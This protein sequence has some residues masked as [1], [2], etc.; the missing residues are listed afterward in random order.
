MSEPLHG[1]PWRNLKYLAG[2]QELEM[3][4]VKAK[5]DLPCSFLFKNLPPFVT[6]VKP[7]LSCFDIEMSWKSWQK[8]SEMHQA[9]S[10]ST[11][12]FCAD[13][14]SPA[15][16]SGAPG[17]ANSQAGCSFLELCPLVSLTVHSTVWASGSDSRD[18]V[19]ARGWDFALFSWNSLALRKLPA[20]ELNEFSHDRFC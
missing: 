6:A 11:P 1:S 2:I 12:C 13:V 10:R 17:A 15:A 19:A 16:R 14:G 7:E 8:P 5:I 3:E 20:A 4:W 18:T 9:R